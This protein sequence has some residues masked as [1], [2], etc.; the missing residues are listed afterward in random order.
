MRR[1]QGLKP[2]VRGE[3]GVGSVSGRSPAG[4][5]SDGLESF[6][7]LGFAIVNSKLSRVCVVKGWG[8]LCLILNQ[9][10]CFRKKKEILKEPTCFITHG[11]K[12]LIHS[13]QVHTTAQPI[14]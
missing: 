8:V 10:P 5:F 12:H 1:Q 11:P 9:S 2:P 3:D 4:G 14:H 7:V 13:K 6:R